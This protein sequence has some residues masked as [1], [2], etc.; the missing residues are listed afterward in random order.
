MSIKYIEEQLYTVVEHDGHGRRNLQTHESQ[1]QFLL[2]IFLSPEY[3][4]FHT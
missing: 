2:A 1:E 3:T 4:F